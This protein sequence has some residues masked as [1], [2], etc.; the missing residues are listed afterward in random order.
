MADTRSSSRSAHQSASGCVDV[1][2]SS[3]RRRG[4]RLHQSE[5]NTLQH[6]LAGIGSGE[7]GT[8]MK[9]I[10]LRAGTVLLGMTAYVLIGIALTIAG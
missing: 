1:N 10:I 4:G 3:L 9:P 5:S 6:C 8:S 7:G 2:R